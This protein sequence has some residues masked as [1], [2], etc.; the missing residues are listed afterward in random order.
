MEE[1][2]LGN[3]TIAELTEALE[4][5]TAKR[6]GEIFANRIKEIDAK[7]IEDY[8]RFDI[9]IDGHQITQT[10]AYLVAECLFHAVI[11][12]V[13]TSSYE[14]YGLTRYD[15]QALIP[16]VNLKRRVKQ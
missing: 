14:R 1:V 7:I 3:A 11:H 10:S 4:K 15:A 13:P 2:T 6:Q 5:A 12:G 16:Y 9:K 8:G